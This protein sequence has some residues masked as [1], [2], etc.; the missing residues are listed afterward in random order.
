MAGQEVTPP[1]SLPLSLNAFLISDAMFNID[2][3][4]LKK[5]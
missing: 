4:R 5:L 2:V 1:K 3:E